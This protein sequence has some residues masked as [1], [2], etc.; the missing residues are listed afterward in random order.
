MIRDFDPL[1]DTLEFRLTGFRSAEFE[2]KGD[3]V[4]VRLLSDAGKDRVLFKD[5][6]VENIEIT[7]LGALPE[8][9]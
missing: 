3:D 9:A 7:V 1:E 5:A 4:L 2:E 8:V 6:E